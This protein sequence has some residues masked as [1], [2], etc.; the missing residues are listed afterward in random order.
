[1]QK[2]ELGIITR[3]ERGGI[4]VVLTS[5]TAPAAVRGA[6][7]GAID[8]SPRDRADIADQQKLRLL[9]ELLRQLDAV[10]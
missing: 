9:G 10:M 4:P 2:F 6:I 3:F 8:S 7:K 5:I 1:M